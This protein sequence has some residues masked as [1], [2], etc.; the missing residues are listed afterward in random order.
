MSLTLAC[1]AALLATEASAA[2]S[3]AQQRLIVADPT[4]VVPAPDGSRARPFRTVGAALAAARDGDIIVLE[5]GL[6]TERLVIERAVTVVGKRG[7]S[8]LV[9]PDS[10]GTVVE[11]R[12]PAILEGLSVQGGEIGV[13][14]L[15]GRSGLRELG[16]SAQRR[17][18][19]LVE[20]GATA[21]VQGGQFAASFDRRGLVG[22]DGSKAGL[23]VRDAR[24]EGPFEFAVRARG[25]SMEVTG[26]TIEGAVSGIACT[27]GCR[28]RVRGAVVAQGRRTGI[29]VQGA[30][31]ELRDVLVSRWESGIEARDEAQL[32]V[33]DSA[34]AFCVQAAITVVRSQIELRHHVHVGPAV[35]AAIA[36]IDSAA[37]I[38]DGVV[39]DPGATG[40]AFHRA[41]GEV[42]GTL[43][44]GARGQTEGDALFAELCEGLVLRHL[45][46]EESS[47]TGLTMQGGQ[48]RGVGLEI[49]EA[50]AGGVIAQV[51]ARLALEGIT[52]WSSDGTGLTAREGAII[53]ARFGRFGEVVAG[54]SFADC[55]SG[56][57]VQLRQTMAPARVVTV[58]CVE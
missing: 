26:G 29:L 52:V 6:Y 40:I 23:E 17:A 32:R 30:S 16:F 58:P 46:L 50:Q 21:E 57:K 7:H 51:G 48:G 3:A 19:V 15:A 37:T 53:E 20:E 38:E 10:T 12:A 33:E 35:L 9:S 56:A 22:L 31:L 36:L 4:S 5:P 24:F 14:V 1:L 45:F 13:R 2:S 47:G 39:L 25:G 11:L 27:E 34:T 28:G 8:V 43:V 55:A 42:T 41:Q 49:A 18:A 44:R 54:P